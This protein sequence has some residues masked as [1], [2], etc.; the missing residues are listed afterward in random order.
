MCCEAV[1]NKNSANKYSQETQDD[2][3]KV[4]SHACI[5]IIYTSKDQY[6]IFEYCNFHKA[7]RWAD[8]NGFHMCGSK[9]EYTL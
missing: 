7:K 3:Y 8:W 9:E 2:D 4:T 5:L 6:I 1:S